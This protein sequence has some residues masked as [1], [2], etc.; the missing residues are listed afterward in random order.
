VDVTDDDELLD[1][2][3]QALALVDPVPA[4]MLQAARSVFARHFAMATSAEPGPGEKPGPPAS[5]GP[6]TSSG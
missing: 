1:E 3:R 4:P 5:D 2:L 6:G